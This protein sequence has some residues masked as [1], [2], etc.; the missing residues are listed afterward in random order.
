MLNTAT[1]I[2]QYFLDGIK[3]EYTG[4]VV[5]NVFER[6]WNAS[7]AEWLASNVSQRE[8][9]ELTQKQIDD[10]AVILNQVDIASTTTNTFS[11]PIDYYRFASLRVKLQYGSNNNCG[12][13]GVS[14]WLKPYIKRA[15][16]EAYNEESPYRKAEDDMIYYERLGSSYVF[17]CGTTSG[18]V[19]TTIRLKYL[20]MPLDINVSLNTFTS[21]A[22]LQLKEITDIAIRKQLERARDSRYSSQ[23]QE[24]S[25]NNINKI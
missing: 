11:L 4:T 12:L 7:Q 13:T 3:K 5:T 16:M 20:S 21:F 2:Y 10:L 8:G 25:I 19:A 14:T 18:S 9:I 6:I 1:E 22:V 17:D 15:D 24:Q 23:M